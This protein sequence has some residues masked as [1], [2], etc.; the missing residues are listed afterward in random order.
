VNRSEVLDL[1]ERFADW[2]PSLRLPGGEGM[3]SFVESWHVALEPIPADLAAAA[4]MSLFRE[5]R[6]FAPT[7]SELYA[8]AR[9]LADDRPDPDEAWAEVQRAIR[10]HGRMVPAASIEWSHPVVGQ[11]VERF[12]WVDLCASTNPVADRAHFSRMYEL[13]VARHD[14]GP[15]LE[16]GS[17]GAL[18]AQVADRLPSLDRGQ[19]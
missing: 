6:A 8:R 19:T 13:A 18:A 12:G 2:W 4:A 15:A 10:R 5:G 3:G 11:T 14:R 16:T 1:I 17:L 7:P 9:R